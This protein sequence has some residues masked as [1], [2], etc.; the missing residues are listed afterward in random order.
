MVDVTISIRG[1]SWD[2]NADKGNALFRNANIFFHFRNALSRAMPFFCFSRSTILLLQLQASVSCVV[3]PHNDPMKLCND[4]FLESAESAIAYIHCINRSKLL[5]RLGNDEVVIA[6]WGCIG[7]RE[8]TRIVST[9][10]YM[11]DSSASSNKSEATG[12]TNWE[13]Q[14]GRHGCWQLPNWHDVIY[15]NPRPK[16]IANPKTNLKNKL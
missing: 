9:D 2:W 5:R 11:L 7:G 16:P 1:A 4:L 8:L 12:M 14:D 15:C 3:C 10:L 6:S 13:Y